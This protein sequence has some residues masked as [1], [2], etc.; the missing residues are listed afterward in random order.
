MVRCRHGKL[1]SPVRDA[2]G[3]RRVCKLKKKSSVGRNRDRKTK[4]GEFHEVR[5][6]KD[7]RRGKR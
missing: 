3:R 7:K 5:Y 4:S 2:N 6:R 1:S